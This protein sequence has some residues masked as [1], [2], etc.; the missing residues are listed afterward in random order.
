MQ[1]FQ[2]GSL[3]V[4]P[5]E[6][7]YKTL[8]DNLTDG[9][10]ISIDRRKIFINKALL[11]IYGLRHFPEA[12]G[13]SLERSIHPE[14]R[15]TVRTKLSLW[16]QEEI[17]M[18]AFEYRV[19]RP[20]GSIRIL[21]ASPAMIPFKGRRAAVAIIHDIT[22]MKMVE[23]RIRHLNSKLQQRIDECRITIE[24][25]EGV[26]DAVC[27]DLRLP[28]IVVERSVQKLAK[29]Y[30]SMP[31]QRF[32][33]V[34]DMI[35]TNIGWMNQLI[36]RLVEYKS[37]GRHEIN[38]TTI[39]VQ[40][41]VES[42][43]SMTSMIY[44]ERKVILNVGELPPAYGD[45]KMLHQAFTNL[46]SNAFKFT[47]YRETAIIEVGAVQKPRVT[48]YYVRDNGEGFDM[49]YRDDLFTAFRR[50]HSPDKFEGTG[51]GLAIVKNIA[52]RHGG[53]VWAEGKVGD[54]ATFY[55]ELPKNLDGIF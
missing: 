39:S 33:E 20:D 1:T 55:F 54:G 15:E 11:R 50:I 8:I 51:T 41:L 6:A 10:A 28:L 13:H 22:E 37:I 46:I 21:K 34:L 53:H 31:D 35:R 12:S 2:T 32:I 27:H 9:I 45:E 44:Q 48:I 3:V 49:K 7:F 14:D 23:E 38:H 18:G 30:A 24:E 52:E 47:K 16:F 29:K 40:R 42:A 4:H 25:L 19:V 26:N 17:K 5:A 43:I 36:D